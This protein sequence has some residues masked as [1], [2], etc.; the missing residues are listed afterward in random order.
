MIK[1]AIVGTNGLAQLIAHFIS[2]T[3]SHQFVILS[4]RVCLPTS[5]LPLLTFHSPSQACLPK[6]GRFWSSI[7]TTPATYDSRLLVSTPSSLRSA[8]THSSTSLMQ[9]PLLEFADSSLRS[10]EDLQ[11]FDHKE[12]FS[13]IT[14]ARPF[15]GYHNSSLQA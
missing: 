5:E 12:T 1:V 9:P 13:T 6:D 8:G 4:R 15:F 3:T 7:T 11:H 10:S 14:A 2:T